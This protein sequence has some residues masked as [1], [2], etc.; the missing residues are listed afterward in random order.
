MRLI[1][2]VVVVMI[3]AVAA[4]GQSNQGG[5]TGTVFDQNGAVVPGATVIITDLGTQKVTTLTTSESGTF[6]VRSLEPV[7]Y[8]LRV[9]ATGFKKAL[10]EKV[11][12]DTAT[13]AA[14]NVT[15]ETGAVGETVTITSDMAIIN[16]ESATTTQT[17]NER[18]IRDL[19]L[20][21]RSVLDL[22]VT[23][24]NVSGDAGSEDP[25]VTSDQPTPGFNL[26]LNGGR[27]QQ[28]WCR[29]CACRGELHAGDGAGV[30]GTNFSLLRRVWFN[31][32]WRDQCHDQVRHKRLQRSRFVV[33]PQSKDKRAPVSH[34]QWS[35]TSKQPALQPGVC[36]CRWSS[37]P[38]ALR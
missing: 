27:C 17:V 35:K 26:N 37:F 11:K 2:I 28:H 10:V 30:Y 13:V 4:L 20:N 38:A 34:R 16:T 6:S 32:W 14:V 24:P 8:S 12:V 9:E 33:S 23:A 29:N 18:Q 1:K 36:N 25:G 21:N 15:L 31:W 7:T 19:P 3:C 22:A 5:I